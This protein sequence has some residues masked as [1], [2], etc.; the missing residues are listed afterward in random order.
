MTCR[1]VIR[2][3][4][5]IGTGVTAIV[6]SEAAGRIVVP[7]IVRMNTPSHTHLGRN[8]AQVDRC[9]FIASLLHQRAPRLIDLRIVS[10]IKIVELLPDVRPPTFSSNTSVC[11]VFFS[12]SL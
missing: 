2:N 4:L 3:C 7:K 5:A 9:H 12:S 1:T 8:I 6:A 10:A 11:G